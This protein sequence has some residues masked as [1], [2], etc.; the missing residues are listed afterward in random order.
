[1]NQIH[2]PMAKWATNSKHLKEVWRTDGVDFKEVTRALGIVWNTELATIS[3]DPL[4]SSANTLK[5]LPLTA[6]SC[7]LR[8]DST[9]PWACCPLYRSFG[10]YYFRTRSADDQRGTKTC[11]LISTHFGTP[12][13]PPCRIW[14]TYAFLDG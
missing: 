8:P 3:M 10:N 11:R 13:C 1:M 7:K 4:M 6:K 2:L 14:L 9:N 5:A 12:G